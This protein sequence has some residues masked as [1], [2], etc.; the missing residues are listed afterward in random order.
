MMLQLDLT[1]T[2]LTVGIVKATRI[3]LT[4]AMMQFGASKGLP[5][6]ELEEVIA[7]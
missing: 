1:K 3:A 4:L 5:Y 6:S 7:E 2:T